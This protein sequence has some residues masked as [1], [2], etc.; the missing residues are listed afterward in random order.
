MITYSEADFA[1]ARKRAGAARQV[2]AAAEKHVAT[3]KP[4]SSHV[5]S[6]KVRCRCGLH[7]DNFC[8]VPEH[9]TCC[10]CYEM[11]NGL[12]VVEEVVIY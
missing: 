4:R 11:W 6:F 10:G 8:Y 9:P 5:S 1:A 2:T 3:P 12:D 7:R